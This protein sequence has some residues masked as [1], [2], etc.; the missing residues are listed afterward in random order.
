MYI[1]IQCPKISVSLSEIGFFFVNDIALGFLKFHPSS[2]FSMSHN[3]WPLNAALSPRPLLWTTATY[4]Q[5]FI[6]M[7]HGRLRNNTVRP[8]S[9]LFPYLLPT[10]PPPHSRQVHSIYVNSGETKFNPKPPPCFF[11]TCQ[12]G[13]FLPQGLCTCQP[14][15]L[16]CSPQG[17]C[18]SCFLSPLAPATK[19]WLVKPCLTTKDT[20]FLWLQDTLASLWWLY[21]SIWLTPLSN[22]DLCVFFIICVSCWTVLFSAV[23]PLPNAKNNNWHIGITQCVFAEGMGRWGITARNNTGPWGSWFPWEWLTPASPLCHLRFTLESAGD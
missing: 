4:N 13:F 22:Y 14:L 9:S 19:V 7:S 12:A 6:R 20:Y 5:G 15:C 16:T 3:L 18:S 21:F 8:R 23:S 11:R 10:I 2:Q 17:T 1:L